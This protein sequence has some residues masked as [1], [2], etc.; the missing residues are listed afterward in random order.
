MDTIDNLSFTLVT[1]LT[2]S[3]IKNTASILLLLLVFSCQ[4]QTSGNYK[5]VNLNNSWGFVD[6]NEKV[7]IPLGIYDFLN[8]IDE[9]NM[10]LAKM[11]GKDGYIDIHQN[12]LI[13]FEFEDLGVFSDNGLAPAKKNGKSGAINRKGKVIVPFIYDKVNYFYKSGL[14]IA[15][16]DDKFGFVDGK[17]K[18]IIPVIYENVDQ[19][20]NDKIVLVSKNKKWAFFSNNG[21]QLT[22][23]KFDQIKQ[24]YIKQN[25]R[26]KDTYF[27]GGLAIAIIG[28]QVQY[29]DQNLKEVIPLGKY[30]FTKSLN[31]NGFGIVG[32][33][34]KFGIINNQGREVVPLEYDTILHPTRYTNILE[35]FILK[36]NETLKILDEN[37]KVIKENILACTWDKID[38]D[39]YYSNVLLVKDYQNKFGII[40][41]IGKTI[42]PFEF[43]KLLPFDAQETTIA[44]KNNKYG[45]INYKNIALIPFENDEIHSN[46]FSKIYIVKQNDKFKLYNKKGIKIID[47]VFED[48]QPCF[49]D[50]DNKFIVR[51]KGKY[52]ITDITGKEIIPNEFDEISNWVEY[53]P[54]AHFV[55]K[56]KKIG[57]Y[58]RD[59]IQL[60]PPIYDEIK[61]VN[62]NII[63]VSQNKKYGVI[64]ISNK[65]IIPLKYDKIYLDR[66]KIT[67]EN[68]EP[69]IYVLKNGIYSQLD[70]NN[71]QIRSNISEKEIKEKFEYYFEK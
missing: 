67:Y 56:N 30:D 40:D 61:Y 44:K 58:S 51:F 22:D 15:S 28:N 20:M 24:A 26:D 70:K 60:I 55:T 4:G 3:V 17:G 27:K 43:E 13:P 18:E 35:L 54:E 42:I 59:G 52:G 62:N 33:N 66:Y 2:Q 12:I 34:N 71:K 29:L 68:K 14:A 57:M 46:K 21:E 9:Q 39:D 6:E 11:N 10:I 1:K 49:Y 7:I 36:K 64:S 8:P 48:L 19:T 31:K 5:R 63:I 32:K 25:G 45:I 47:F 65:N 41:E 16:K 50:Q 37:T 69:E 23:F 38:S 53:G